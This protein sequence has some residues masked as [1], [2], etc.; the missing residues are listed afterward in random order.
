MRAVYRVLA[1]LVAI[2]VAIQAMSIAF[3]TTGLRKWVDGGGVYDK[4]VLEDREGT[5]FPEAVG[6]IVH[7]MNGIMVIPILA[8]LL[9]IASLF[10]KVPRGIQA[11]G[12]V[13]L[14]V[15]IQVALGIYG[16]SYPFLGALHGLNALILLGAALNAARL[17]SRLR[18]EADRMSMTAPA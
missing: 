13:L 1:Y 17:A 15:V 12:L 7:G 3:A 9:L 10:A 2:G 6:S 11:A 5:P 4:A 8:L 18:T 14:L 16:R